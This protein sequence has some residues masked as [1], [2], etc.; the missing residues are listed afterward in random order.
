[1]AEDTADL[2]VVSCAGAKIVTATTTRTVDLRPERGGAP[3]HIGVGG[4]DQETLRPGPSGRA[5]RR[6][7]CRLAGEKG[8]LSRTP[9]LP[10]GPS[11]SPS[12]QGADSC[13]TSS[14][15]FVLLTAGSGDQP[16][17]FCLR[18]CLAADLVPFTWR[19]GRRPAV[20]SAPAP[21]PRGSPGSQDRTAL[22]AETA[23]AP[24]SHPRAP[25]PLLRGGAQISGSAPTARQVGPEAGSWRPGDRCPLQRLRRSWVTA[26][27]GALN[28]F[29]SV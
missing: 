7:P 12:A 14:R 16:R 25:R 17:G 2:R 21:E 18:P 8:S 22:G 4:G 11:P 24:Y 28:H 10:L 9:F 15:L 23:H 1:M 3:P 5:W 13:E 20:C 29:L 27:F 26:G 6:D 19:G